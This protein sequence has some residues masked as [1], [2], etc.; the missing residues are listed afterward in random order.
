[1]ETKQKTSKTINAIL[2]IAQVLL[3]LTFMWAAFMKLFQ[4]AD[5]L[6]KMWSWTADNALLVKF[7][8]II[9]LA[10]GIG[11]VVPALLRIRPKLTI[12]AAYGTV[13]LMAAAGAFHILRGEASQIGFNVFV[14]VLAG[15]IAWGRK[16]KAPIATKEN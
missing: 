6:A 13:I 11:L 16:K 3:A 1:M 8:G 14:A 12:Y 10:A 9:D 4:S 15:F 2:W 7:T 5:A